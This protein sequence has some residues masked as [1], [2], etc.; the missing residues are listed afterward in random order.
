MNNLDLYVICIGFFLS[1]FLLSFVIFVCRRFD[2]D[3]MFL[4]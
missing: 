1:L 3:I 2:F 4:W